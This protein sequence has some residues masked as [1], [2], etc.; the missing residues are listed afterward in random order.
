MNFKPVKI[1]HVYYWPQGEKVLVGRLA[2][3]SHKIFFEYE[4]SF[5]K[6]GL[7][8]SPF[9][10]PL[11]SGVMY[12][13]DAVFDG[14][15]GVFNDS[16][17]DGWGRLLLDRVL[18]KHSINPRELSAIDRLCFVG[19]QG[20]GALAYEPEVEQG[21]PPLPT[22]LETIA[23]EIMGFQEYDDDQHLEELL[24]MGGSSAGVRPKVLMNIENKHWL[25]KFPSGTDLKDIGAIEYAYHLMA[26]DAGLNVTEAKLFPSRKSAGFF[27]NQ[28]FDRTDTG[29]VH[30]H[31]I[32]GLLHGDHRLP[33]L[34][35]EMIMRAT[36]HLTR[37]QR[38][39]EKQYRQCVF[40]VLSHNR[41]D[42]AKNF[43]F[44]MDRDG[45]WRT[46]PAY[47]LT[48]SSGPN[49]EH[50]SMVM[51]E[52]KNPQ[53]SHLLELAKVGTIDENNALSIIE[54]VKSAVEKWPSFAQDAGVGVKNAN[55]IDATIKKILQNI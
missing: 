48:F 36:M 52:G 25:I 19:S 45:R 49:G 20:M 15:F 35:Y 11:K 44:L 1:V 18:V 28:R 55:Q 10:L 53:T 46:S 3:K 7:N 42:H 27:A 2:L 40:N 16:L 54:E 33:S 30:M 6:T 8:I 5:L 17:P 4:P 29:R 12:S 24:K 23:Q 39:W 9:K 34:D 38:E 43:S 50:C 32:S 14:L 41:D 51:G 21:S 13:P 47:D 26:K 31:S 22:N 37:D